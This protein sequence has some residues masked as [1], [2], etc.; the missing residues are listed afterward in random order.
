L[1]FEQLQQRIEQCLETETCMGPPEDLSPIILAYIGD[2]VFCLQI[3][4]R[5]LQHE[6]NKVRVLHA[7]FS[8]IGSA[9]FQ[10]KLLN[11]LLPELDES[12][13]RIIRRG[14]NAPSRRSKSSSAADY[15]SSTALEALIGFLYLSG[16]AQRLDNIIDKAL[17][18]A[19]SKDS[20]HQ[21]K[22]GEKCEG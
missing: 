5:L 8:H 16:S 13:K 10:A 22:S 19:R 12:E 1:K 21:S 18:L 20:Q 4:L 2:A 17:D 11:E 14:R 3:R 6:H 9:S 7:L 15:R